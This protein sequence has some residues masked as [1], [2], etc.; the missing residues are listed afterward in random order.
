MELAMTRTVVH[1]AVF[2]AGAALR[3]RRFAGRAGRALCAAI[4]ARATRRAL[5]GL[6]D[7]LLGDIGLARS[8][9]PFVAAAVACRDRS[10]GRNAPR[11]T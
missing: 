4:L 2:V 6:P 10:P 9:I 7:D 3:F 11:A 5:N 1:P 8:D